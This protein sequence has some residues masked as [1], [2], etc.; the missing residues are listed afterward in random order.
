MNNDSSTKLYLDDI[1][2]GMKFKSPSVTV[3]EADIIAFGKQFDPQPFHTDPVAAVTSMFNGLCAS[4]WHT[5][6]LTM[7]LFVTSELQIAG[8][9]IGAGIEVLEWPK[10][11]R[12]GD[13]L[14]ADIEV[15]SVRESKT[16][17]GQG[18]VTVRTLTINQHGEV[19]QNLQPKVVVRKRPVE[20]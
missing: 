5:A 9:M 6:A 8:G 11:V 14:H 4:G 12:P 13:T 15:I 7:R 18:L 3:S 16:R 17:P 2:V 10:P 20:A 19:V 1:T